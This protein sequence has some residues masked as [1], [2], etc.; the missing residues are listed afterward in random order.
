MT[1]TKEATKNLREF[2]SRVIHSCLKRKQNALKSP[3]VATALKLLSA[4][5]VDSL[6]KDQQRRLL[7]I[8]LLAKALDDKYGDKKDVYLD[9]CGFIRDAWNWL[10]IGAVV[11]GSLVVTAFGLPIDI[12][13]GNVNIAGPNSVFNSQPTFQPQTEAYSIHQAPQ[14]VFYSSKIPAI[15]F[16]L[17]EKHCVENATSLQLETLHCSD[18]PIRLGY[19]GFNEYSYY[20]DGSRSY[21]PANSLTI[22]VPCMT[23]VEKK[24][25]LRGLYRTVRSNREY[26]HI[27]KELFNADDMIED[28]DGTSDSFMGLVLGEA[29]C[30]L[31]TTFYLDTSIDSSIF[32]SDSIRLSD[33]ETLGKMYFEDSLLLNRLE[34]NP[35]LR[36][37]FDKKSIKERAK[38]T[39]KRIKDVSKMDPPHYRRLDEVEDFKKTL[40]RSFCERN[41]IPRLRSMYELILIDPELFA[42]T[43]IKNYGTF[44]TKDQNLIFHQ[45]WLDE[46]VR[47]HAPDFVGLKLKD[48]PLDHTFEGSILSK[49]SDVFQLRALYPNRR[50]IENFGIFFVNGINTSKEEAKEHA[51]YLSDLSGGV[52]VTVFYNASHGFILDTGEALGNI[53]GKVT[54]PVRNFASGVTHFFD[55]HPSPDAMVS[56]VCHSQGVAVVKTS[57][58]E[59]PEEVRS[60]LKITAIA[61]ASFVP[62]NKCCDVQH[63]ISESDITLKILYLYTGEKIP[64]AN[65]TILRGIQ[66]ADKGWISS[67]SFQSENYKD[68]IQYRMKLQVSLADEIAK[69]KEGKNE[70]N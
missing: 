30:D 21:I 28:I 31:S 4:E 52:D 33:I 45:E 59:L 12:H 2:L 6:T 41:D 20:T 62:E 64:D 10:V 53:K 61:P 50:K 51:K 48:I 17:H 40:V 67:H 54:E 35:T 18:I 60:M 5:K 46:C 8:I 3:K 42:L 14:T 68:A 57:L 39:R 26:D 36:Y 27:F 9:N 16:D 25:F 66:N 37:L 44:A 29:V 23:P 69:S 56:I 15:A 32:T 58:N 49:F 70:E 22:S 47:L 1:H 13:V 24:C 63:F 38:A 65:V 7:R 55:T 43:D 19:S 34:G 11:V